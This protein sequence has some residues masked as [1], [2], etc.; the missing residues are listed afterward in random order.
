MVTHY[1]P[2]LAKNGKI[3][4]Q[5]EINQALYVDPETEKIIPKKAADVSSRILKCFQTIGRAV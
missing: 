3:A 1:G 2:T 5:I 4:L